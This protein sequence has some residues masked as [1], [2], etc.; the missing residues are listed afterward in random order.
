[1]SELERAGNMN[2]EFETIMKHAL[3]ILAIVDQNQLVKYVTP[4]LA[5]ILGYKIE[6]FVGKNAFDLLYPKGSKIG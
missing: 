3:D 4:S 6:D 1:M 5:A 2:W